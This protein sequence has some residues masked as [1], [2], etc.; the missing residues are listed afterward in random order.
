MN[1]IKGI[2]ESILSFGGVHE[3]KENVAE[4]RTSSGTYRIKILQLEKFQDGVRITAE[5]KLEI[6]EFDKNSTLDLVLIDF[7]GQSSGMRNVEFGNLDQ[8]SDGIFEIV[9]KVKYG[10][11]FT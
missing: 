8:I 4:I 5:N 10:L 9:R 1:F 2:K 7:N 6:D 11:V 3:A